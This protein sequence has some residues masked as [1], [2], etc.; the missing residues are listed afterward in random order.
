M[1]FTI[2]KTIYFMN[3][4]TRKATKCYTA[5]SKADATE[6]CELHQRLHDRTLRERAQMTPEERQEEEDFQRDMTNLMMSIRV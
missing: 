6:M 1:Y 4:E 3:V 2:G 5:K